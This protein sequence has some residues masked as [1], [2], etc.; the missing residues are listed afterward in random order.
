M[1][2]IFLLILLVTSYSLSAQSNSELKQHFENYYNQMKVQGDV[3]GVINGLTHLN[4]IAPSQARKDTLAYIYMNENMYVEALNTIGIEFNPS[5]SEI[6]LEVKALCLK[7][8]NQP[9]RA[10]PHFD[11]MFK[12]KPN[13]NIAYDLAELNMTLSQYDDA[14]KHINYGIINATDDMKRGYFETK[15]PYEV[16]LKAGFMYLKALVNFNEN[17]A[18]NIDSA[19]AILDEAIAIAPNFNLA[20]IS[21][22]ALLSQKA[23]SQN[24]N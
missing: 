8:V 20:L 12:R 3:Q 9:Q 15:T 7:S 22:N 13:A 23:Q 4:V 19:V 17:R 14:N 1:K 24:K 5:D 16:S 6:A 18:T 2:N 11:E 21:K 10:L